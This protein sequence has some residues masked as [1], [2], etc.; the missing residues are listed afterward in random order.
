MQIL[1]I[2]PNLGLRCQSSRVLDLLA[3]EQTQPHLRSWLRNARAHLVSHISETETAIFLL[4]PSITPVILPKNYYQQF[5]CYIYKEAGLFLEET[6][7]KPF[8]FAFLAVRQKCKECSQLKT[9]NPQ[10]EPIRAF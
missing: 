10:H 9:S 5:L 3:Q 6:L 1:F 8:Y 7:K 4:S 2:F